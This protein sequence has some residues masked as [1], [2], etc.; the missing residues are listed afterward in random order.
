MSAMV[1]AASLKLLVTKDIEYE[2]KSQKYVMHCDNPVCNRQ[3][4]LPKEGDDLGIEPIRGRL[5][6]DEEIL[7]RVSGLHGMP[8]I[9]LRNHVPVAEADKYF[10]NY[11]LTPEFVLKRKGETGVEVEEKPWTVKD[12]SG[13]E[14]YSLMAPA[15]VVGLIKQLADVLDL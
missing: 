14:S 8:K 5:E 7:K 3:V 1:A 9:L 15:V 2:P 12:D 4:M 10:D 6:K 11:E 13:V